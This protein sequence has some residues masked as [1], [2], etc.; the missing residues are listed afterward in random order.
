MKMDMGRDGR[1]R[2]NEPQE[3]KPCTRPTILL[4]GFRDLPD[5]TKEAFVFNPPCDSWECPVCR[6]RKAKQLMAR[7][8]NAGLTEEILDV[9]GVVNP[10]AYKLLT[11]TYGGKADKA[12]TDN[13]L[14]QGFWS[15]LNSKQRKEWRYRNPDTP[16]P[17]N[18]SAA[19]AYTGT[20]TP[21][22][23]TRYMAEA[24][25]KLRTALKKYY[26]NFLFLR[27]VEL[28]EDGYPHYHVLLV[29]EAIAP[30]KILSHITRLW[31]SYGLGFVKLNVLRSDG[32]FDGTVKGAVKYILKYLFKKPAELEGKCRRYSAAKGALVPLVHPRKIPTRNRHYD[33]DYNCGIHAVKFDEDEKWTWF[34]TPQRWVSKPQE[35]M[36]LPYVD[37]QGIPF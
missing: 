26:G 5:G 16:L 30:A 3:F 18:F 20:A 28:H 33:I 1:K 7:A 15:P 27:V 29:G 14:T 11:L 25:N 13:P 31:R 36:G 9:E 17:M 23:V 19:R 21:A 10:Y 34:E 35:G 4:R 22:M 12:R 2:M 24:W 32:R 37:T 6:E 8:L